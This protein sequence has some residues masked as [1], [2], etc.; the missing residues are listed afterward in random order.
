MIHSEEDC[1]SCSLQAMRWWWILLLVGACAAPK[2]TVTPLVS[3]KGGDPLSRIASD[4]VGPWQLIGRSVEGRP[5][6]VRAVGG[7]PRKVLWVGGI[8]GTEREGSVATEELAQVFL[9]A[10]LA[11]SVTLAL[12]RDLN[13]DGTTASSR[14]NARQVDL[15]RNFPAKNFV[16]SRQTG[17][18][19]LDQ[20]EARVLHGL[21]LKFAPDLVIVAHSSSRPYPFINYDGPARSLARRFSVLSKYRIVP[22]AGLHATPGS[23]GSWV[24]IDQKIPILTVEW[25]RGMDHTK[26]WKQTQ[27]AILSIVASG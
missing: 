16:S 14:R 13:P 11:K 15:N 5:I 9:D 4:R 2:T 12:V 27:A 6:E 22:S 24:G 7:G 18:K 8:H 1:L 21:I 25:R 23:L 10:G 20:P 26:A 19:P 3:P 17:K